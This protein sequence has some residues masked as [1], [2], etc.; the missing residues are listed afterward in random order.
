MPLDKD[1]LTVEQASMINESMQDKIDALNLEK[2]TLE[3]DLSDL[4]NQIETAKQSHNEKSNRLREIDNSIK[5]LNDMIL[6]K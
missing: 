5:T 1:K 4:N 6:V 2:G 3:K